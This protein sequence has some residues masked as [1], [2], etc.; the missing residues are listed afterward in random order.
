[1]IIRV[2]VAVALLACFAL[3]VVVLFKTLSYATSEQQ[4]EAAPEWLQEQINSGRIYGRPAGMVLLEL[5][6]FYEV[7]LNG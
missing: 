1:M 4:I 5:S 7:D 3:G 2:I 6:E